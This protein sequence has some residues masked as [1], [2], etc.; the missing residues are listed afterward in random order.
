MQVVHASVLGAGT[1]VHACTRYVVFE[2][3]HCTLYSACE[4]IGLGPEDPLS[5]KFSCDLETCLRSADQMINRLLC[6]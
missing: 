6:I 3:R 1:A 5:C 2:H 4:A